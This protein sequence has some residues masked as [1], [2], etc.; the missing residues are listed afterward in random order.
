MGD[1]FG[2]FKVVGFTTNKAKSTCMTFDELMRTINEETASAKEENTVAAGS[3]RT[4]LNPPAQ[5]ALTKDE[6]P[7]VTLSAGA[8]AAAVVVGV[9]ALLVIVGGVW[10]V[11]SKSLWESD[12]ATLVSDTFVPGGSISGGGNTF[13]GG[14]FSEDEYVPRH[15]RAQLDEYAS[16]MMERN[17]REISAQDGTLVHSDPGTDV[18]DTEIRTAI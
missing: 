14:G 16:R 4:P 17:S 18:Q 5:G 2:P 12:G 15:R 9:G 8:I 1:E 13:T 7:E 3:P 10:L 6:R 11:K